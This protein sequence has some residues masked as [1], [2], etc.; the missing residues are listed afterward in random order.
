MSRRNRAQ[1]VL[2]QPDP[3]YN[4]RL[5]TLLISRI[6]KSGK[7]SLAQRI[8]YK[9]LEIVS[10]KT[11]E[12]PVLVLEKA[13]KNVT[14][15]VEVK[16]RRVGGST[17]QVPIEIRAYRGTNVSLKWITEF[18]RDRAGKTMSFKLANEIMDAAK[19]AG[20]SIRKKEQTHK[21][22]EANKAFAHFRY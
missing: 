5:V 9:S 13:V 1:R 8:V 11:E 7:K 22:A 6:L 3:I 14:P 4:S 12:N 18:S 2:A 20:N 10:D 19:E 16:A 21:M 15:Q 17:Y